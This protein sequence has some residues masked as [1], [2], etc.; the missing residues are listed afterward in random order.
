[1]IKILSID[2]SLNCSGYCVVELNEKNDD[3]ILI[4]H[5]FYKP[6]S[7]KSEEKILENCLFFNNLIKSEKIELVLLE[8]IQAQKS[9]NTFKVL[10][11]L[12]GALLEVIG[13]NHCDYMIIPPA[14]WRKILKVKKGTR[15]KELKQLSKQFVLNKFGL[16]VN[17]DVADS[18]CMLCYFIKNYEEEN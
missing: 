16:E 2:Q 18:I 12:L 3:F 1:M 13:L 7:T 9:L 8:N 17:D 6:K 4:K 11:M 5:G 10:A 14:T 15:R